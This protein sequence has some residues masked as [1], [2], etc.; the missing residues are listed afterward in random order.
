MIIVAVAALFLAAQRV[1]QDMSHAW[2]RAAYHEDMA[3]FHRGGWPTHMSP[4]DA[5]LLVATT[6]RRPDLAIIH[7]RMKEKWQ[8]AAA[9][10]WVPVDPDPLMLRPRPLK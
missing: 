10:P 2:R 1:W 9:C 8:E 7:S 4:T 3:A 6:P 5:A